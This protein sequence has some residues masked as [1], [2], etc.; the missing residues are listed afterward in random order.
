MEDHAV[1]EDYDVGLVDRV[2]RFRSWE[3][4]GDNGHVS[5]RNQSKQELLPEDLMGALEDYIGDG[6]AKVTV[7]GELGHSKDYGCKA[8]AFV[9]ISVHCNN[10]A[11][12]IE[13]VKNIVQ[14][15]VRSFV[16]E[17]LAEMMLDRDRHMGVAKEN[18]PEGRMVRQPNATPAQ[19][20]QPRGKV[21]PRPSYKR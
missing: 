17:D 18:V 8:Q 4:E 16:N 19:T 14:E 2:I 11:G 3:V 6:L 12:T 7:G 9:S 5:T 10:D 15:K 1:F 21:R 20:Q 13:E